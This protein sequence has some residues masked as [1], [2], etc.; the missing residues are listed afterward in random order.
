MKQQKL[1]TL[2]ICALFFGAAEKVNAQFEAG[3][4]MVGL[5]ISHSSTDD[6]YKN[7]GITQ[8]RKNTNL[9]LLPQFQYFF[10]NNISIGLGVAMINSTS[11]SELTWGKTKTKS[12]GFGFLVGS[13]IYANNDHKL[14]FFANPQLG[15]IKE[16]GETEDLSPNPGPKQMMT[17]TQKLVSIGG[18][19]TYMIN[20]NWGLDFG[21]GNLLALTASDMEVKYDGDS[22]FETSKAVDFSVAPLDL[23]SFAF[24]VNFFF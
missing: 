2:A 8:S 15:L 12:S 19:F 21:I 24:A 16:S 22:A 11:E 23:G 6:A 10:K 4:K 18:G 1:I 7:S 17:S 13:R 14:R 9:F 5:T 3:K 20:K